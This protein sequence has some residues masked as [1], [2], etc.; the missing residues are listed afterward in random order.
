[1][2][3]SVVTSTVCIVAIATAAMPA[4]AQNYPTKPVRIVTSD[5]G[6][7][8]D[9][10]A[11]AMAPA[12]SAALGQPV[13]IDNRAGGVIAGEIVSKSPPDGYTLIYYGNTLWILPLM[14]D[15][16]P[17]DTVKDFAPIALA[18]TAPN[19]LVV[20]P[21]LPVKSVKDL[22]AL[23]K[24]RPGALNYASAA[25]GTSNHLAAEL[26]K[27]MAEV[28]IVRIP[29]KGMGAAISDI[30]AGQVQLMF[31]TTTA[32][33]P[34]VKSGRL[35]ALGVSGAQRSAA[36]PDLPTIAS[37]GLPGYES[38][39]NAGVLAPAR[40]PD[41]IMNRLNREIVRALTG[42]DLKEKFAAIGVEVVASSSEQFA[43]KI[44]SEI[45]SMGK[46]IR[47]AGIRAD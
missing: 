35:R 37:S 41:T 25:A 17:Y 18:V 29:Y 40:T 2:K 21:S 38:A 11:R 7:G 42:A 15:N 33:A 28:N 9:I 44:K 45:A 8:S 46:G 23:A 4:L 10:V 26:F 5:P 1:M 32:G 13:I 16:V 39:L 34:H 19:I 30:I 31:A 43:A 12:M 6:G 20:H 24:A 3:T 27:S 47:D 36:Y 22:I 14:R